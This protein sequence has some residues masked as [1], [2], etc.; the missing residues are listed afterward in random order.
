MILLCD[1]G[2]RGKSPQVRCSRVWKNRQQHERALKSSNKLQA[3]SEI[4]LR[5]SM[6]KERLQHQTLRFDHT[7]DLDPIALTAMGRPTLIFINLGGGV[8]V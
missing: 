2:C 1:V 5:N 8:V 3:E 7:E 6:I 4:R